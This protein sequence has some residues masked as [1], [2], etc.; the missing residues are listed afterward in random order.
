MTVEDTQIAQSDTLRVAVKARLEQVK[1][2][3]LSV[4][5]IKQKPP[6]SA[7]QLFQINDLVSVSRN[8]NGM[9]SATWKAGRSWLNGEHARC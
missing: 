1:A 7:S 9:Q 8:L 2:V 5:P 6:P 4:G 3:R